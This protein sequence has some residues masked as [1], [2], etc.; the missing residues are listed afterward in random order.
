MPGGRKLQLE[1]NPDVSAAM[2]W[3]H[4][5]E[6]QEQALNIDNFFDAFISVN[7]QGLI[8]GWNLQ[9]E[10][11]FGWPRRDALGRPVAE[12]IVPARNRHVLEQTM[13]QFSTEQ[14]ARKSRIII[15]AL[16]LD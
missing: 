3:P 8:T 1:K 13:Q 11:T 4:P 15:S 12:V 6:G 14:S 7:H 2:V 10:D 5:E 16:H 9:A